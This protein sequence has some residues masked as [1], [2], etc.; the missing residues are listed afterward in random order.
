[1]ILVFALAYGIIIL[2]L[3]QGI[4]QIDTHYLLPFLFVSDSL[5]R[6][7]VFVLFMITVCVIV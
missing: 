5:R 2:S 1:M 3:P 6:C 7:F 4:L